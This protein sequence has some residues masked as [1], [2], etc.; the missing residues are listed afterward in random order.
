MDV[1]PDYVLLQLLQPFRRRQ[2]ASAA[3]N[4]LDCGFDERTTA[5][6]RIQYPLVQGVVNQRGV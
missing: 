2:F 4:P 5:A 3:E 1:D 6:G